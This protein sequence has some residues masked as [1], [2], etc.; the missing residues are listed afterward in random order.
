M[1]NVKKVLEYLIKDLELNPENL[2]ASYSN[3]K[4]IKKM[5]FLVDGNENMKSKILE[6]LNRNKILR[7]VDLPRLYNICLKFDIKDEIDYHQFKTY[8]SE[9]YLR[10][11]PYDYKGFNWQKI[12]DPKK[13]IY[14]ANK[15][16]CDENISKLEKELKNEI[17]R[18]KYKKLTF[19]SKIKK[20]NKKDNKIPLINSNYFYP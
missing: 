10:K 7:H 1:K 16:M 8:N 17:G 5:N 2:F 14:Y 15:E 19:N 13:E 4:G 9:I 18:E 20:L 6:L 12:L 3:N 11:E